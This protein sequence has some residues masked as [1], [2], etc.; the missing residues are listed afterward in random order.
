MFRRLR[1]WWRSPEKVTLDVQ[2]AI[3]YFSSQL[4]S[5][6]EEKRSE[7]DTLW[8]QAVTDMHTLQ[9]AFHDLQ[10]FD[11]EMPS[12][13]SDIAQNVA[14]RASYVNAINFSDEQA[15]R[16]CLATISTLKEKE[17]L[18]LNKMQPGKTILKT[19]ESLQNTFS[20]LDEIDSASLLADYQELHELFE[21]LKSCERQYYE[22]D[23]QLAG[24]N[25]HTFEQKKAELQRQLDAIYAS[26]MWHRKKQLDERISELQEKRTSLERKLTTSVSR[27]ERCLKKLAYHGDKELQTF[28]SQLRQHQWEY[29]T[30]PSFVIDRA[31][32]ELPAL[33]NEKQLER[34]YAVVSVLKQIPDTY[35][36]MQDI[37]E[38][39]RELK[40]ERDGLS[41][42]HEARDI[43]NE[44]AQQDKYIAQVDEQA[45]QLRTILK[46]LS[47][48]RDGYRQQMEALMNKHLFDQ[49]SLVFS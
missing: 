42:E 36:H 21:Q 34:W 47:N 17:I 48:K 23:Q 31:T 40:R 19:F 26:D 41:I 33:V 24:L 6:L 27:I 8:T 2:E 1:Q 32:E 12:M 14:Q 49:Y 29:L 3:S 18:V 37:E 10:S 5:E 28:S 45:E 11:E 15:V 38:Q 13:F 4:S 16:Q 22:T 39:Q 9:Q 30:A 46:T 43:Q 7:R 20:Q 35:T 25:I 44:L